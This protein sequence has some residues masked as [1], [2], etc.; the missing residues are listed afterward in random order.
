MTV[1]FIYEFRKMAQNYRYS[2][3]KYEFVVINL[4][5]EKMFN[6]LVTFSMGR[7]D[8]PGIMVIKNLNDKIY[9]RNYDIF[10]GHNFKNISDE[11]VAS[12]NQGRKKELY[13]HWYHSYKNL[14]NFEFWINNK[15]KAYMYFLGIVTI[16]FLPLAVL[17][18]F[19]VP[20]LGRG[21][22]SKKKP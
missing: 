9:F 6:F 1:D 11:L 4:D 20:L 10:N 8:S 2:L 7:F 3:H 19:F 22:H 14:M 12:I 13:G 5:D 18:D 16:S 21:P 17:V 15:M